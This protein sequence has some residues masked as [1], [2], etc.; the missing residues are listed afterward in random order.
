MQPFFHSSVHVRSL[1]DHPQVQWFSNRIHMSQCVLA[2]ITRI[3]YREGYKGQSAKGKVMAGRDLEETRHE[4]PRVLSRR[5]S[6]MGQGSPIRQWVV[7]ICV[8]CHLPGKLLTDSMTRVLGGW[9]GGCSYRPPLPAH[10]KIL[11]SRKEGVGV[12]H[13]L[14]CSY[15]HYRYSESVGT[16]FGK[17]SISVQGTGYQPCSWIPSRGELAPSAFPGG[18]FPACW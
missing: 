9:G 5:G 16:S 15:K 12:Q 13:E 18:H 3:Y 17:S 8:K 14:F 2:L 1:R 11:G 10:T 7:T 4:I 6:H